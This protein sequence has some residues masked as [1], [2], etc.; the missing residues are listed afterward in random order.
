MAP[1]VIDGERA[2]YAS[3]L[4]GAG[5]ILY[6]LLTGAP[7]FR[8]ATSKE[9]MLQHLHDEVVPPSVRRPDRGISRALDGVVLRALAKPPATRFCDA[10]AMARAVCTAGFDAQG[11]SSASEEDRE[12]D[13]GGCAA[14]DTPTRNVCLPADS[15]RAAALDDAARSCLA[16]VDAYTQ[17][18]RYDEAIRALQ[19]RIEVLRFH[20]RVRSTLAS[21]IDRLVLALVAVYQ[22]LGSEDVAR[23]VAAD[24]DR[25]P[26][27]TGG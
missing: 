15:R 1:E 9:V 14:P 8:G 19:E 16:L 21:T 7:P 18:R 25:S 13:R 5:V 27:L 3:D 6:E 4:Y 24:T 26:T 11:S 20:D 10:A 22:L 2:T 17:Q 12:E 23:R